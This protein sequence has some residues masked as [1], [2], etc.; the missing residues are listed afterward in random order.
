[1]TRVWG[2]LGDWHC[3]AWSSFDAAQA[4]HFIEAE[5]NR[6]RTLGAELEWKVYAHDQPPDLLRRLQEKGFEPGDR[7]AVVVMELEPAPDWL[8]EPP[9]FEVS[10]V[11]TLDELR[12]YDSVSR[13]AFG[14]DPQAPPHPVLD[15]LARALEA[16]SDEHQAFLVREEGRALSAG[17]LWAHP[18]SPFVELYGGGTLEAHRG[19]GLYRALVAARAREARRLGARWVRVDA[20]PTSEPVLKRLGFEELTATWPCLLRPASA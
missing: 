15:E 18:D 5:L 7:E 14:G 3:I 10:R 2:E 6:Q 12:E 8:D 20:L 4:D 9:R 19:M 1:L 13:R 11:T 17:R 16:G